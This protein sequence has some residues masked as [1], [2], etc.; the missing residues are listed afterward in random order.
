MNFL[1]L[2]R[3]KFNF[4]SLIAIDELIKKAKQEK[5]E[6][7][8][9][10]NENHMYGMVDF[11]IAC[12]ENDI[13]GIVGVEFKLEMGN[14][15][16]P[17]KLFVKNEEGYR[18]LNKISTLVNSK[19]GK[20]NVLSLQIL[21][22]IYKGLY[23][24]V[25]LEKIEKNQKM[26]ENMKVL[27]NI[28]SDQ[29]YIECSVHMEKSEKMKFLKFSNQMK[30][31]YC[32][33][34]VSYFLEKSEQETAE[35]LYAIKHSLKKED[36]DLSNN[37]FYSEKE[38][39]EKYFDNEDFSYNKVLGKS[40]FSIVTKGDSKFKQKTPKF[41]IPENF[42]LMPN[43]DPLF[44]KMVN[45]NLPKDEEELKVIHYFI[46]QSWMGFSK[47]Y[48][49]EDKGAIERLK[50]E[51]GVIVSAGF[52]NYFLV[53]SDIIKHAKQNGI[54]VTVRGS[55]ISSIVARSLSITDI[56]PL[57]YGLSF[58]RFLNPKR[59]DAPDIDIDVSQKNR[60]EVIKYIKMK[61][62]KK[63]MSYIITFGSYGL[64]NA[65]KEAGKV[66]GYS[67]KKINQ[68]FSTLSK[69][70]D[71]KNNFSFDGNVKKMFD[72]K[73]Q[74]LIS[75]AFVLSKQLKNASTNAAGVII[76]NKSLIEEMPMETKVENGEEYLIT[77]YH[78]DTGQL[79][80]LGYLKVDILGLR[81]LDIVKETKDL[82]NK[83]YKK[84]I[85][86]IPLDDQKTLDLYK[87]GELIGIFQ[88]ESEGMRNSSK[89]INPTS[90]DDIIALVALYRPGPL[91]EI[92]LYAENKKNNKI[93]TLNTKNQPIENDVVKDV[94]KETYGILTYQEQIYKIAQ[95][96]A[97][98]EIADAELFRKAISK[99]KKSVLDNERKKFV[100]KS[101]QNN[102]DQKVANEL[103]DLIVKFADYGLNKA[104]ATGYAI[105]SY[106]TAWLKCNYPKEYMTV[107]INSVIQKDGK[108]VNKAAMYVND[109]K[110]MGLKILNPDINTSFEKFEIVD[111]DIHF[112]LSMIKNVGEKYANMIVEER[113]KNG[114][115][116]SFDDFIKR[117][118][119]N[120]SV[121]SLIK[122]GVFDKFGKR[123]EMV[124]KLHGKRNSAPEVNY[125]FSDIP[126]IEEDY[127]SVKEEEYTLNEKLAFE[128]ELLA[129]Y[130]SETPEEIYKELVLKS[131]KEKRKETNSNKWAG[132]VISDI[133]KTKTKRD[134]KEMAFV[135]FSKNEKEYSVTFF[136]D[137]WESAKEIAAI[138]EPVLIQM[139]KNDKG[140][141]G[142]SMEKIKV[143]NT[144]QIKLSKRD[145]DFEEVFEMITIICMENPGED[146]LELIIDGNV[147]RKTSAV[148]LNEKT[149]S[150]LKEV[151]GKEENI[152]IKK[153][154]V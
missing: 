117:M 150:N 1:Q 5:I 50:Y 130:V 80:K 128:K 36:V 59:N 39:K 144:A 93:E 90:I 114:L 91:H 44:K 116:K 106:T 96:V 64:K 20:A 3:T 89:M 27:K 63:C 100:K 22:K 2:N 26:I 122:V 132:T 4:D 146:T 75:I 108:K 85:D 24:L 141:V 58:E 47:L 86:E 18:N 113:E 35:I 49:K 109:S 152:K 11:L 66:M 72:E 126:G 82:I 51:L 40:L 9:A 133:K 33:T 98:Y 111:D 21:R 60:I 145:K 8:M 30:V 120:A 16:Y 13:N 136:P 29:V 103:Y 62:G 125:V 140:L 73:E 94:L 139:D 147:K 25:D 12:K 81:N 41:K 55:V 134:N 83:R 67:D 79:E 69:N 14:D 153:S 148:K 42:K 99:K 19:K 154:S 61:Y 101:V 34:S 74:K 95:K 105:F 138:N 121:E 92:K 149:I 78:N 102:M 10:I 15:L 131:E 110:R 137:K 23:A 28:F 7:L 56:C 151:V 65:L 52:S 135:K 37:V 107:L 88:V 87:K 71:N 6:T 38:M 129:M 115:F 84:R 118:G 31:Q 112:G 123:K 124:E 45:Y 57:K 68:I 46:Y 77:Q 127:S 17:I 97:G 32:E 54:P 43:I 143:I 48:N 70:K 53:I 119:S 142:I 76:G 104:H